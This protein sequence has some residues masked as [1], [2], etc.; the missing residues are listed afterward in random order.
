MYQKPTYEELKQR[1]RDLEKEMIKGKQAD[2]ALLKSE[3]KYRILFE[4]SQD[5]IFITNLEGVYISSNQALLDLFGLTREEIKN[6]KAQDHY[7]NPDERSIIIEQIIEKGFIRNREVKFCKKD[8]EEMDCIISATLRKADDG[9]I[10]GYQGT[11][12]DITERKREKE[13]LQRAKDALEVKTNKLEEI[14]TALNVLLEKREADKIILQEQVLSNVKKLT[15]PYIEKLR[16]SNLD[17]TQR[18]FI[19][20]LE[21]SL[22]EII[23][24]LSHKLS[25]DYFAL[26][27]TEIKVADFV[28]QGKRTK[29]IAKMLNISTKTIE[30]HREGIRNKLGIK[31]RKINLQSHLNSLA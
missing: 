4:T 5:A 6:V 13:A 22:H 9:S 2:E 7:S 27:P 29:Q 23:S 30:R 3:E 20:V 24:P 28:R 26:T 14:N 8:G 17:E 1:V 19:D 12:R 10:L 25:S 31:N 16:K 21:Y 18:A 15:L 11:A